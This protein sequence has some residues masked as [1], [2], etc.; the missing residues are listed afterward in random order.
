MISLFYILS[1]TE[2]IMV[3]KKSDDLLRGRDINDVIDWEGGDMSSKREKNFFQ[4]MVNDG[5]VWQLQ[6]MYGRRAK[7]LLNFGIIDYPKKRTYDA[8]GNPIP[9]QADISKQFGKYV[10]VSKR[11]LK[12]VI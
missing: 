12:K 3:K 1:P 8:Y 9:T 10:P 7:Q 11:N 4:K 2:N 6:G 5:S